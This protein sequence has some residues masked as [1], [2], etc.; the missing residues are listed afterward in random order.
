MVNNIDE[1]GIIDLVIVGDYRILFTEQ[2][3]FL[4]V[5][6]PYEI[7]INLFLHTHVPYTVQFVYDIL[8]RNL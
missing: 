3:L 4:E 1:I 6:Q 7:V 8:G 2:W 5:C